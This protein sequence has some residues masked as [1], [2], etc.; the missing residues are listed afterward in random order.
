MV[1]EIS[2]KRCTGASHCKSPAEID[3]FVATI[4]VQIAVKS[5][6]YNPNKYFD[7]TFS[8]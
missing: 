6:I 7:E 5:K 4:R 2:V 3:N 1:P 8:S